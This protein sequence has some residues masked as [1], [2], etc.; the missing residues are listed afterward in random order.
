MRSLVGSFLPALWFEH[1]RPGASA[2][3]I[4]WCCI[5]LAGSNGQEGLQVLTQ[6]DAACA[7]GRARKCCTMWYR[8]LRESRADLLLASAGSQ[9]E[10]PR[11]RVMCAAKPEARRVPPGGP[12]RGQAAPIAA[13]MLSPPTAVQP[14]TRDTREKGVG[15]ATVSSKREER[16]EADESAVKKKMRSGRTREGPRRAVSIYLSIHRVCTSIRVLHIIICIFTSCISTCTAT[17]MSV[18]GRM[19]R[20]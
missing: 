13:R 12:G 11:E 15:A 17:I 18:A 19:M 4:A 1:R 9:R 16:E 6:R 8:Y 2:S 14:A 5:V 10:T 3:C 20:G 7:Q